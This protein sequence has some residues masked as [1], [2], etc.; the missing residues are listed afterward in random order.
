[1]DAM[2]GELLAEP[3]K[4]LDVEVKEWLELMESRHRALLAKEIVAIANHSSGHCVVG[5]EE[6]DLA[7]VRA[8][9]PRALAGSVACISEP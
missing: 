8:R 1:M 5:C 7:V 3:R 2:I 9:R 6:T 4:T